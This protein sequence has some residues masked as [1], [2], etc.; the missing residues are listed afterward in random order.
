MRGLIALLLANDHWLLQL[1]VLLVHLGVVHMS[2]S[3]VDNTG[4]W[5]SRIITTEQLLLFY[6]VRLNI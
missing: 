4:L 3:A 5:Y 6:R 1:D 2:R